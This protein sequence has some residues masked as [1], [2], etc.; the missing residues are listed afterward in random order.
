MVKVNPLYEITNSTR[1][2]TT[3]NG[4]YHEILPKKTFSVVLHLSLSRWR[5][6]KSMDLRV[7]FSFTWTPSS[8]SFLTGSRW[9]S[10]WSFSSQFWNLKIG[11]QVVFIL[12][13]PIPFTRVVEKKKFDQKL[14]NATPESSPPSSSF[15]CP[16]T[17]TLGQLPN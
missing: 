4:S 1:V 12:E 14:E 17:G 9:M 11:V 5:P 13:N 8:S 16:K 7:P 10:G 3:Y 15:Y 6:W 2:L